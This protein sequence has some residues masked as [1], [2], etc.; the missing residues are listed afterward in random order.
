MKHKY[1]Y[2][3]FLW[4]I[5]QE[6]IFENIVRIDAFGVYFERI[7]KIEWLLLLLFIDHTQ[8]GTQ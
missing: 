5:S 4:G 2:T 3:R 6:E 1:F 7:L 8:N